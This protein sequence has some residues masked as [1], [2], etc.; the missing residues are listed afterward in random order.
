MVLCVCIYLYKPHTFSQG[1]IQRVLLGGQ[2]L[3]KAWILVYQ[4]DVK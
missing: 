1:F 4:F 2:L 3:G